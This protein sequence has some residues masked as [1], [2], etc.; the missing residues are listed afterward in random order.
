MFM[1]KIRESNLGTEFIGFTRLVGLGLNFT[2]I[3]SLQAP[4][5]L[6]GGGG[7][8]GLHPVEGGAVLEPV[9]LLGVEGVL[10]HDG[11]ARAVGVRQDGLQR[12]QDRGL[13]DKGN[14]VQITFQMK[15]MAMEKVTGDRMKAP[16][17]TPGAKV[18][19]PVM[20]TRSV[21][22]TSS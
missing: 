17:T 1:D 4:L 22:C 3:R 14:E 7:G 8:H 9:D 13:G 19:R 15:R 6:A 5:S 10:Q 21:G 2:R 18:S 11:V 20:A 12:L 16:L